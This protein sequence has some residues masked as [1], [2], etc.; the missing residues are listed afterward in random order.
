MF[1]VLTSRPTAQLTEA[2]LKRIGG[3][4]SH[5]FS[6]AK[7]EFKSMDLTFYKISC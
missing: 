1:R 5:K 4:V 7:Y 6:D 3:S 2:Q